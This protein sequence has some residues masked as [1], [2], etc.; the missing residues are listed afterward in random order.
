MCIALV[1]FNSSKYPLQH[2]THVIH[3]EMEWKNGGTHEVR[4][5]SFSNCYVLRKTH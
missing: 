2:K 3:P 1:C 5:S 4:T